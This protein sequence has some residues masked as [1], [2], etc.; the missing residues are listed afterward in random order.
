MG[1]NVN[2]PNLQKLF[3]D[4]AKEINA[5]ID[6]LKD[7]LDFV[8]TGLRNIEQGRLTD[9]ASVAAQLQRDRE[10]TSNKREVAAKLAMETASRAYLKEQKEKA[11]SQAIPEIVD[12]LEGRLFDIFKG[13]SE[14]DSPPPHLH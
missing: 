12:A 7:Q 9:D 1:S 10:I 2:I 4:F 13:A 11:S 8:N 5:K 3:Q 6:P 14:V